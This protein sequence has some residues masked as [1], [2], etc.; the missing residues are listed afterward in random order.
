MQ[1]IRR[2]LQSCMGQAE[3]GLT[4]G[5]FHPGFLF[6]R[7]G[8]Q[9]GGHPLGKG[10]GRMHFLKGPDL[11]LH[12]EL[13]SIFSIQTSKEI[14]R[15]SYRTQD[16]E[17]L[18]SDSLLMTL[19]HTALGGTIPKDCRVNCALTV[20]QCGH[21]VHRDSSAHATAALL[22][23]HE[24]QNTPKTPSPTVPMVE[25]GEQTQWLQRPPIVSF[26]N[27]PIG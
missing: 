17:G 5:V 11:W 3:H 24:N 9:E 10:M 8:W 27:F 15:F 13:K 14:P 4:Q 7:P 26:L 20:I 6:V 21:R 2:H 18:S 22:S 1:D 23:Q 16:R 25:K 12:A 19:Y